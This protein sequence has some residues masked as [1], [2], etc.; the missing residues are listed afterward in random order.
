MQLLVRVAISLQHRGG[1]R[2]A[3]TDAQL[4]S[5]APRTHLRI[6]RRARRLPRIG[7]NCRALVLGFVA[8]D[9]SLLFPGPFWAGLD[10]HPTTF[11]VAM[12]MAEPF[13]G[14]PA[15]P[16][17]AI[18]RPPTAHPITE[19]VLGLRVTT[20]ELLDL[21]YP[22]P[23]LVAAVQTPTP[24]ARRRLAE[25]SAS[26]AVENAELTT[27]PG[28]IAMLDLFGQGRPTRQS[29]QTAALRRLAQQWAAAA[30]TTLSIE[31]GNA[32]WHERRHRN[33]K[34]RAREALAYTAADDDVTAALG[35]TYCASIPHRSGST[36]AAFLQLPRA[37]WRA[38][39]STENPNIRPCRCASF[40]AQL[41]AWPRQIFQSWGGSGHRGSGF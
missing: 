8:A 41:R 4:G 15:A 20:Q 34:S 33:E 11:A 31:G 25:W 32:R 39:P 22:T 40:S 21:E 26:Q 28:V 19:P 30:D 27:E 29:A 3:I 13:T 35:A 10:R 6:A 7:D 18:R 5:A 2:P 38:E 1:N 24:A 37:P 17:L 9:R 14:I 36:E 16:D 12:A 23:E